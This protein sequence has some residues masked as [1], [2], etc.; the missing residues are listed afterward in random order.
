MITKHV[1]DTGHPIQPYYVRVAQDTSQADF[2]IIDDIEYGG[3]PGSLQESIAGGVIWLQIEINNKVSQLISA[4]EG[5][6]EFSPSHSDLSRLR[7]YIK[8]SE[9]FVVHYTTDQM[10]DATGRDEVTGYHLGSSSDILYVKIDHAADK[11]A[12]HL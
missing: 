1:Y 6:T 7:L 10:N 2:I 12:I 3:N 5:V 4:P 8:S 11:L 9:V